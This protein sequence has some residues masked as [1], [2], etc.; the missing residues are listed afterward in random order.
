MK[1]CGKCGADNTDTLA[2][3]TNC[4]APLLSSPT[5]APTPTPPVEAPAPQA[6]PT[7]TPEVP[8]PQAAPVAPEPVIENAPEPLPAPEV[9]PSAPA[10]PNPNT[11]PTPTPVNNSTPATKPKKDNK[12][13]LIILI[14]AVAIVGIIVAVI[15]IMSSSSSSQPTVTT[16]ASSSNTASE[17]EE[18]TSV[19]T[20]STSAGTNVVLGDY[21][22]TVPKN[23][24]YEVKDGQL[25]LGDSSET[26]M[27]ALSYASNISYAQVSPN[28]EALA[29]EVGNLGA[30]VLKSG[31]DTAA[32]QQYSYIDYTE[33]QV[34][35]SMGFF[36]APNDSTF[37]VEVTNGSAV[38][39]HGLFTGIA[40]ILASAKEATTS[41]D[42]D[43]SVKIGNGLIKDMHLDIT[44]SIAE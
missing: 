39:D 14:A 31:A 18:S 35:I 29:T 2:F 15:M 24:D 25:Y 36:K 28:L 13:I 40:P 4:G 37:I 5:P 34:T 41:T 21:T 19:V 7:E 1:K 12:L 11:I 20:S 23:F 3:C 30:T 16:T 6:A 17:A 27:A 22:L 9:T 26:W 44:S 43:S 38:A 32:R 33:N 8:A 10:T 42:S